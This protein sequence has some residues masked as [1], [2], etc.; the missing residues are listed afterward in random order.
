MT[1]AGK[2]RA[3]RAN[4]LRSTGPRTPAGRARSAQNARRHGL[5]SPVLSDPA[6]SAEVEMI[7]QRIAGDAD[8]EL[9][10]LA[11][12]IAEAEI[13]V[14]KVRRARSDRISRALSGSDDRRSVRRLLKD[15]KLVFRIERLLDMGKP[16]PP[17]LIDALDQIEQ[18]TEFLKRIPQFGPEFAILDRYERRALSR[19]KFAI[20]AFDAARAAALTT[21]VAL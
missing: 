18:R 1:S 17:R 7:A 20:R 14:I 4:S 10:E 3:N 16:V 19:R 21:P 6:L 2:L 11:R 12:R 9:L 15:L 8:P 13:D 5:G